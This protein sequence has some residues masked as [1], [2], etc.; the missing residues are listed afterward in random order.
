LKLQRIFSGSL[1]PD[2]NL[3]LVDVIQDAAGQKGTGRW[4]VQ[5]ALELAVPIPTMIAAVNARIM[6]FYKQDRVAASKS[7]PAPRASMRGILKNL[8]TKS[9]MLS[10]AQRFVP[11]LKG[12]ALL[13]KASQDL[14]YNLALSEIS[15]IWK[16]GLYYSRW[17]PR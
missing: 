1:T 8:S 15:R 16:G 13:S 6:S 3:P 17:L 12:M 14:N 4:T 9:E 2:T 10:T 7:Y 11:M 5:S